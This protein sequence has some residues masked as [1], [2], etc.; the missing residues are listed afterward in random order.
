VVVGVESRQEIA[1]NTGGVWK[2]ND[3][4]KFNSTK[5]IQIKRNMYVV[6]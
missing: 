2:K 5:H 3:T 1:M 6:K 4:F